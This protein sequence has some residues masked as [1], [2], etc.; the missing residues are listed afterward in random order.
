[1]KAL[2]FAVLL[3]VAAVAIP[4]VARAGDATTPAQA[5]AL[6]R[7][8][9]ASSTPVSAEFADGAPRFVSA[10]VPVDGASATERALAYLDAFRDLYGLSS[11]REQLQVVRQAGEGD[12]TS[13]FFGQSVRGVPVE[14]A[15]LAVH[16]RGDSVVAT[17]G[18]YLPLLPA[19]TKPVL[20]A[21]EA[22]AVAQ[23]AAGRSDDAVEP[24]ELTYFNASLT[25]NEAERAAW[26]L[27]AATHLAWRVSLPDAR[28]RSSTRGR[29]GS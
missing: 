7:L 24:A 14:D 3:A 5:E 8:Q 11:P 19:G 18:A 27:D 20:Y 29:V 4:G 28:C 16:L 9:A 12:E 25:M 10:T 2:R 15:Q 1:M 21:E 17:N 26:G 23:T 22:T 13:I 6:E